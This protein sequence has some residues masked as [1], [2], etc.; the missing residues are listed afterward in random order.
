MIKR[1]FIV[2]NPVDKIEI[3]G[4]AFPI[5]CLLT[6]NRNA[7]ARLR[8]GRIVISI[9]SRWP[10]SERKKTFS[11]LLKRAV[12]SIEKG[13]WKAGQRKTEFFHGQ[14]LI[15][16]GGEL[17]MAFVPARRFGCAAQDGMVEVKVVHGHPEAEKRAFALA[18]KG[19]I[20]ILMPKL[21][22][23]VH[24]INRQHFNSSISK[25]II[26]DNSTRWGS[27]SG[28]KISLN[29]RLL[30]MP[31][32]ILDYVIV[33][34]LAHTH[35]KSHGQRFWA[36]VEKVMPDHKEKRKWLRENGWKALG[37]DM[38]PHADAQKTLGESA[39]DEP[40]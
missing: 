14:K 35:Y 21:L 23:R 33:H 32:G 4:T 2:R 8:E 27:C 40:Y 16:M 20:R 26:R 34:E 1:I 3:A 18:R 12:R 15:A 19:I 38:P 24:E 11:N 10:E 29:F 37:S 6:G 39:L 17:E 7:W 30:F 36:L 25:V 31:Q 28:S 9:P 5:E 13:K 22:S